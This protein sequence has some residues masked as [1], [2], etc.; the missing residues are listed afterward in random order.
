MI[1]GFELN[2]NIIMRKPHACGTNL[3]TVVRTGADIKIKCVHCGRIV[4]MDRQEF[5]RGAKK[6]VAREQDNEKK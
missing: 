3:W 5:M 1:D 6:V 2:D 4:M